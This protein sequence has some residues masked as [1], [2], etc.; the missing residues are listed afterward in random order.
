MNTKGL[1]DYTQP[2]V[3]GATLLAIGLILSV[4]IASLTAYNVKTA[5]DVIEVTGSAKEAVVA[6]FARWTIS[7]ETKTQISNQQAGLNRLEAATDK[8]RAYLQKQGFTDIETPVASVNAEYSY[9]QYSAPI[10]TGFN[11]SRQI[12]VRSADI[13][14]ISD[15]AGNLAPLSGA[16][17]NVTTY[18]L[19][20]TYQKLPEMRVKLLADAIKDA[21]AR[22]EAIA[23]ETGRSVGS[24]RSATGGVVQVLSEGAVDIS[25]Y[26]SY[27]TQSMN[28]DVMVTVRASFTLR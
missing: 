26:G 22:A 6:D 10:Q 28:K 9:P 4:I 5:G 21:K 12:V 23:K 15:L 11:V 25:D 17:Y 7:L 14:K 20:L 3:A 1:Y 18:G 8:I 24:L 2:M 19:E 13:A 16:S 27:D